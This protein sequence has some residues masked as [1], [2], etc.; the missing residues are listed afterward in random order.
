[1]M[2]ADDNYY[3]ACCAIAGKR[4]LHCILQAGRNQAPGITMQQQQAMHPAG[5]SY[6]LRARLEKSLNQH[7]A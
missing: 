6:R 5:I 2:R 4:P 1:M 7:L 3:S